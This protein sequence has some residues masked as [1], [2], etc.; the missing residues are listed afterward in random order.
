[1]HF[2]IKLLFNNKIKTQLEC[3][4]VYKNLTSSLKIV[5]GNMATPVHAWPSVVFLNFTYM[6]DVDITYENELHSLTV[7]FWMQCS[8]SLIN[9][10]T[11]LTSAQCAPN[12]V[13]F[14]YRT[15]TYTT[16]VETNS[17]YPTMES[18]YRVI[19]GAYDTNNVDNA[20]TQML[21]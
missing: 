1:M 4:V 21:Q 10:R 5:G 17:Y 6:A 3:G 11:V 15:R 2:S 19:L 16:L 18:M 12:N 8:G 13:T 14:A 7:D 20:T 9:R